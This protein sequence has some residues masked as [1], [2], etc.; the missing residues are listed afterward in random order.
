M[1]C[2]KLIQFYLKN[3]GNLYITLKNQFF[4][5][6]IFYQYLSFFRPYQFLSE[7]FLV[8]FI[9]FELQYLLVKIKMNHFAQFAQLHLQEF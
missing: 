1:L 4:E 6:L 9:F 2:K 5:K 3:V 7:T 8:S